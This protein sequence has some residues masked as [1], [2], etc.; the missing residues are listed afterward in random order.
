[1][2]N[3][4]SS[5]CLCFSTN[6]WKVVFL[7]NMKPRS[8]KLL[9]PNT[10]KHTFQKKWSLLFNLNIGTRYCSGFYFY[11]RGAYVNLKNIVMFL[12]F[13]FFFSLCKF[14]PAHC[15]SCLLTGWTLTSFWNKTWSQLLLQKK[16]KKKIL[17]PLCEINKNWS[18]KSS[19]LALQSENKQTCCYEL[20]PV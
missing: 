15:G 10:W 9:S 18:V 5:G 14:G 16:E 4:V 20:V 12:M 11:F 6:C 8:I 3:H 17:S 7:V 2:M 19:P 1:M 13:L